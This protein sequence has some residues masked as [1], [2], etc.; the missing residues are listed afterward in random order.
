MSTSYSTGCKR[1][2]VRSPGLWFLVLDLLLLSGVALRQVTALLIYKVNWVMTEIAS[3]FN[4]LGSL[5]LQRHERTF[6]KVLYSERGLTLPIKLWSLSSGKGFKF[7]AYQRG[8]RLR[9][10]NRRTMS[11]PPPRTHRKY[12]YTWS[13]SHWKQTEDWQKD[14]YTTKA[15]KKDPHRVRYE[16]KRIGTCAPRRGHRRG[17]RLQG[18]RDPPW[19]VNSLNH[20]LGTP[21]PGSNT[22]KSSLSWFENQRD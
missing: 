2:E 17:G 9:W 16:E 18:L 7:K 12:I 13:N 10:W 8:P 1:L 3:D 5:L 21:A 14:S 20:I 4:I 19:G 22:R 6:C 11:S 15:V